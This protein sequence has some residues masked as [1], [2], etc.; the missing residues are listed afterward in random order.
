M[1]VPPIDQLDWETWCR[2]TGPW[3]RP[4][5]YQLADFDANRPDHRMGL[6]AI[7]CTWQDEDIIGA[8]VSS[9]MAHGCDKVLVLDNGSQDQTR[10]EATNAGADDVRSYET[11]FYQEELRIQLANRWAKYLVT[12]QQRAEFWIVLLDADEF[13]QVPGGRTL[14]DYLMKL[15]TT[16]RTVGF[17][18]IDLYPTS[19]PAYVAGLHP[20]DCMDHAWIRRSPPFCRVPHW[21]HPLICY[22]NGV[23][24]ACFSRGAHI[25][26][27]RPGVDLMEPLDTLYLWH[28][29]FREESATRR[30]LQALCGVQE[31]LGGHWRSAADDAR[32]Q[33]EGAIK[34]W[35]SL[36]AVYRGR[37]DQVELPHAQFEDRKR[38]VDV[39]PV[40]ELLSEF[41]R[42]LLR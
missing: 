42:T 30:R 31:P 4:K 16:V 8:A 15:E 17:A 10:E 26:Y 11:P 38:G 24:D 23:Y 18:S 12:T 27:T 2:E 32:L 20:A 40:S 5:I 21:K 33:G 34:R 36:D 19:S 37:W 3:E 28:C 13:L 39:R 41:D 29:P 35:R 22:R 9:A 14:R 1:I 25:P 7:I 6:Y